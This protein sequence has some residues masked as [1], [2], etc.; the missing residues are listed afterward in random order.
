MTDDNDK[1]NEIVA[2]IGD[3]LTQFEDD[4]TTIG[5]MIAALEIF[6]YALLRSAE[7][8]RQR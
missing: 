1:A 8:A 4:G 5:D 6:K 2:A 3:A 7:E